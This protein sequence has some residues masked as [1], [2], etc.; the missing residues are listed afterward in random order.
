MLYIIKIQ[1]DSNNYHA[2]QAQ[3]GRTECWVDGYVSVPQNLI[4][5][6]LSCQGYC[7]LEITG[8]L[9]TNIIPL[10]PPIIPAEP[11]E[12][13]DINALLVDHEYRLTL[14]ELGVI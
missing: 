10:E 7:E 12:I 9:L 3:S 2:W 11:T 4:S 5:V 13:D 1:G 6:L 8:D 14:I